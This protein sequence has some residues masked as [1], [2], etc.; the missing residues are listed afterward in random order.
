MKFFNSFADFE[1][2]TMMNFR[3]IVSFF[4]L[5]FLSIS[6]AA[7]Y[8]INIQIT[9]YQD[10]EL[11]ITSYYGDKVRLV[12]TAYASSPGNFKF[13]GKKDLPGGIYMAVSSE[14]EKLF[15][16]VVDEKQ[17]FSLATDTIAYSLNMKVKGSRENEIFY[18]YLILNEQLFKENEKLTLK[19]KTLNSG[20][21]DYIATKNTMDSIN[22]LP[23]KYRLHVMQENP[24]FLVSKIFNS[25]QTIEIPDSIKQLKDST[26]SFYYYKKHFFDYTDLSDSRLLR[27]PIV[28][29]KVQEYFKDL[30][31]IQPDSTITAIDFVITKARPSNEVVSYLVWNFTSEYQNPEYMGFDKVFVHIVDNYFSKE[32]IEN[33]TPSILTNLQGRAD[34]M[35]LSMIGEVAPNLILI[36]TSGNY[37]TFRNLTNDYIIIIFWDYD[38]GIC[39]SDIIELQ[40]I[41]KKVWYDFE[42]YAVNVNSG[43]DEWKKAVV[44]KKLTWVNVNGTRSVTPD[45]HDLYDITGTPA[46]FILDKN[47][48]IIAKQI[49]AKQVLPFLEK[50]SKMIK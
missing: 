44:D 6:L 40:K 1:K 39:K 19:L 17:K 21:S 50:Y 30:V 24:G 29:K 33:T 26:A 3:S 49:G 2:T 20:D 12:D 42:V 46:L 10:T 43:L 36:D 11:L 13:E 7:Q 41:Y 14:K 28:S 23:G 8:S 35:R 22:Q 37:R 9:G 48:K 45:F 25:M 16:F 38:C 34:R 15:E 4:L 18:E 31:V 5:F 47:R 32:P 27:T